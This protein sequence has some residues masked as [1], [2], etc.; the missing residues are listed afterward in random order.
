MPLYLHFLK[1]ADDEHQLDGVN[2]I[3]GWLGASTPRENILYNM[4]V[5]LTD[6]TFNIWY[7]GSFAVRDSR[8]KLMHTYNDS[9]YG[10][11]YTPE[12]EI[13]G[14]DDLASDNRCAQQFLTGDFSYWLFDL[15]NDPYETTNLYD[16]E[17]FEHLTAK[18]NLYELLPGFKARAKTKISIHW[19]KHANR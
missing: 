11:W 4:Y 10:A 6:Y 2:Q 12:T 14:D 8:W 17:E 5:A 9:D 7:N 3:N 19:S 13:D 18:E 15:E 1:S 16:S